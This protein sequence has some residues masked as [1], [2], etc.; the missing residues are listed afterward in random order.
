MLKANPSKH[1]Y[2][3]ALYSASPQMA[4][5]ALI[6]KQFFEIIRTRDVA[7]WPG[8]SRKHRTLPLLPSRED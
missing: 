4:A 7:A 1:R 2:L 6:A 5:I 3:Q 8:G